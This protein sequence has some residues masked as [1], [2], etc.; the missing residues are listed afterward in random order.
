M[1]ERLW[2]EEG[3]EKKGFVTLRHTF[4]FTSDSLLNDSHGSDHFTFILGNSNNNYYKIPKEILGIKNDLMLWKK[5]RMS[6]Q[7]F[8][9]VQNISIFRRIDELVEEPIVIGGDR[10]GA[11]PINEFEELLRNFPT[12]TELKHYSRSRIAVTLKDYFETMSDPQQKMDRYLNKKRT[13]QPVSRVEFIKDYEI[14]KFEYVRDEL[15]EMLKH[16]DDY[17]EKAW[18]KIV[19]EFLLLIF[20]KYL[21]VLENV[22]IKDFYSDPEKIK[23]RYIDLALVDANGTVDIVEIKKPSLYQ[24]LASKKYRDNFAPTR[25]LSGAVMQAEKYIFHLTK[26]GCAGEEELL[27][28]RKAELPPNFQIK[29]TNPK[30]I[31]ILGRDND[32]THDQKFDFE[33]IKRKYSNIVD[34]MT[35]DDLLRRLEN[36]ISMLK[37]NG[38]TSI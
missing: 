37:Q 6:V 8:I 38:G 33:I 36:I 5:M 21:V 10:E 2:I 20:P 19:T 1:P 30:A 3:L 26:W 22:Q 7:T 31:I 35:Y 18:Q 29:I 27:K 4:T 32:F 25:E 15:N 34:I 28:K 13:I 16:T 14:K 17:A 23:D 12:T 9:A 11:I 24:V